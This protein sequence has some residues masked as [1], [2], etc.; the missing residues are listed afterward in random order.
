[1]DGCVLPPREGPAPRQPAS[2]RKPAVNRAPA[3]ARAVRPAAQPKP[4]DPALEIIQAA[5]LAGITDR[6]FAAEHGISRW[7][8]TQ[9]MKPGSYALAGSVNGH[10][11]QED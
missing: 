4:T 7:R 2:Q 5:L 6:E 10:S 11:H 8:A 1:V 9:L 3:G